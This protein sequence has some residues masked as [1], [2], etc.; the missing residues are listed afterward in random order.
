MWA[1]EQIFHFDTILRVIT[2][3]NQRGLSRVRC[4]VSMP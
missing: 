1:A 4:S 3:A 2:A